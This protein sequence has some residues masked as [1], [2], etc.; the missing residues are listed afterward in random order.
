MN[1]KKTYEPASITVVLLDRDLLELSA[2]DSLGE[3][4]WATF[5]FGSLC[6]DPFPSRRAPR[7]TSREKR[8]SRCEATLRSPPPGWS[9]KK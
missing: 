7:D 1:E 5:D 3:N 9:R 8:T 2:N 6:S 4:N